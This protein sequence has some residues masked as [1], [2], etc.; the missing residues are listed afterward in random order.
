MDLQQIKKALEQCI[1][2]IELLHPN[3]DPDEP[4]IALETFESAHH[5]LDSIKEELDIADGNRVEDA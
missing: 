3:L 2:V 1:M 5:A 4:C